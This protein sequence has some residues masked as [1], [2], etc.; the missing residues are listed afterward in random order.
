MIEN[1]QSL[2]SRSV[3]DWMGAHVAPNCQLRQ[4]LAKKVLDAI[5]NIDRL[6]KEYESAKR[7]KAANV[8]ELRIATSKA[9]ASGR[10]SQRSFE[11]HLENHRCES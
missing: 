10:A 11:F 9:R 7:Q 6:N 4:E 2:D 5:A 8:A 1:L 3:R